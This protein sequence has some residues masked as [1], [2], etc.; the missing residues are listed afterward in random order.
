M[1]QY[2][3]IRKFVT[4]LVINIFLVFLTG[5]IR[6]QDTCF[7][8]SA[9][10]LS[11][12]I[13]G[14]ELNRPAFLAISNGTNQPA[15]IVITRYNGGSPLITNQTIQPG[16][17]YKLDF[18]TMSDMKTVENPRSLAGSVTT[19]GVHI[20]SDVGVSAYY[21]ANSYDSRDIFTLKG[22][23]ALGDSFYVPMQDAN[24]Y[25]QT[26]PYSGAC[27]QIDIVATEDNTQVTVVP[28]K[29]VWIAYPAPGSESPAGT[30]IVRTLNRGQ[31][32]K[33]M[34]S[35]YGMSTS[36][37]SYINKG[38]LAGTSITATHPVAVTV[39]EDLVAGDTSGDQIV[40]VNSV[41]KRYVIA[42]GY[43]TTAARERLYM[44]ATVNGTSIR[45]NGVTVASGMNA[46]DVR[47]D[48]IK[49][50]VV[51]VEANNPIYCYQRTGYN[52]QGAALLPSMY[53]ISQHQITFLQVSAQE[54][55]GFVVYKT[56]TH[57]DFTITYGGT[58][59][60]LSNSPVQTLTPIA[61]PGIAEWSV[62]RFNLPPLAGTLGNVNQVMTLSN[63]QSKFSLGYIGANVSP[64]TMTFYGYLSQFGK[65]SFADTI[66]MCED[67]VKLD[68]GYALSYD[69]T[70]PDGTHR[71]TSTI[72][73]ADTGVYSVTVNLDPFLQTTT[74][75]LIRRFQGSAIVSSSASEVGAGSYT[76]SVN[77]GI[78]PPTNIRYTWLIDGITVSNNPT[79]SAVWNDNE[80][81]EIS[82][83]LQDTVIGCSKTHVL[84][85][86]Q[87]P[88][89]IVLSD[90]YILPPATP[91]SINPPIFSS[92]GNRVNTYYPIVVGD[93]NGDGQSEIITFDKSLNGTTRNTGNIQIFSSN[94][95]LLK[96]LTLP[97]GHGATCDATGVIGIVRIPVQGA[98]ATWRSLIVVAG[99]NGST[100]NYLYAYAIDSAMDIASMPATPYWTSN[101]T[102]W[103]TRFVNLGFADFNHD[104]T[105]EI[106]VGRSI[107][108]AATGKLLV[109]ATGGTSAAAAPIHFS[110]NYSSPALHQMAAD[111]LGT[112]TP[113][114]I[115]GNEIYEV[116]IADT[117]GTN[118]SANSYT[119]A[120][121]A[122]SDNGGV[123][124]T[125]GHVC[126]ADFDN[127]GHTDILITNKNGNDVRF[128]LWNPTKRTVSPAIT[129]SGF[130]GTSQ[131][132]N[133]PMLGDIDGDG[134]VEIVTL[135]SPSSLIALKYDP[136][137]GNLSP[138]YPFKLFWN[139][140]VNDDTGSTGLTMF[141]FNQDGISELVY[142]DND[143]LRI[144]NGSGKSHITHN[145]T[146]NLSGNPVVYNLATFV[147]RSA[148]GTEYPVIADIDHD[149]KADIIITGAA[150]G[151]PLTDGEIRIFKGNNW[152]P[153]RSVWNQYSY[154]VVNV[155]EDLSVPRYQMNP[156]MFFPN[157]K[158]P[159]N[160]FLQQQ[161]KLDRNGNPLWLLP[162]ITPVPPL[163]S[164][165][166]IDD[167]VSVTVAIIN[168]GDAAINP[169]LHYSLYKESVSS[170]TF[171][172]NDSVMMQINAGETATFTFKI[173]TVSIQPA[174]RL[175]VRIND[176]GGLFTVQPE[177]KD[178]NNV[179]NF[180][181]PALSKLMTKNSKINATPYNGIRSNP[182]AVFHTDTILYS[183]TAFNGNTGAGVVK[184]SDVLPAYLKYASWSSPPI[185]ATPAGSSPARDSLGWE[186]SGIAPLTY[187]TVYFKA[188]PIEGVCAS[189]PL[190][191]NRAW[192]T[193]SDTITV[194]T[195]YTY[196]QGAG[197]CFI[198]FS[199]GYGGSI[200]HAAEQALDYRTTPR[201]G[202]VVAPNEGY[203]FAGWR[204]DEYVSLRGE[205][206]RARSGI[207]LYDTLTVYGN[208][209]L[210]AEFE[211]DMYP[212]TYHLNGG[213]NSEN[214]PRS[215]TIESPDFRLLPPAKLNDAF[216]GWTGSNGDV[217]QLSVTIPKGSTGERI[218]YA[219]YLRSGRS[220]DTLQVV[221][222]NDKVWTVGNDLHVRTTKPGSILRI[223][224]ID[225]VL[226][227]QQTLL[228]PGETKYRLPNGVYII[229]LNN[230]VGKKVMVLYG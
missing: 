75:R 147:C 27:D 229:T 192:V 74:T 206:I 127:D 143:S 130:G 216:T 132:K 204:H 73:A 19:F 117:T 188:T 215:Y 119:L 214:N 134:K 149:G 145:D 141:D 187:T 37:A 223:Y 2:S 47:M 160:N 126:I 29:T 36:L 220:V 4:V 167:S 103:N 42:K 40:P 67:S 109:T 199:A 5:Q 89:N 225:G 155:N 124:T 159:Y 181:N 221:A 154:N 50:D 3:K 46:G 218:Y 53:S 32:L 99:S 169:P 51:Y 28:K 226:I 98:V 60:L 179:I 63:P 163:S 92:T 13:A 171:I 209:T 228:Q 222:E 56:G 120:R 123:A 9:P 185:S 18:S 158:Q 6:A 165:A 146:L 22:Q 177:C 148:T 176:K 156:A 38:S 116:H 59:Y 189:Q 224:S 193:V 90:C 133:I 136:T 106:H 144:I 79:Y 65:L 201:S 150:T 196:H 21:M 48:T 81:R 175:F 128:Y 170:G 14:I 49:T 30:P 94:A 172:K 213:E 217:P 118:N 211:L 41:G 161:T 84:V 95:V 197:V 68:A 105:P 202:I 205:K 111:V 44:I 140:A 138:Y 208:M 180:I 168:Q 212:I 55:K 178:G 11:E 34:E 166:L 87:L 219:N 58:T 137:P 1:V 62:L 97:S 142:R 17:L 131:S 71:N 35:S 82:M 10:H 157:G 195:N 200:Y 210:Q 7:W 129:L 186:I 57:N 66:Y 80:D 152:A 107:F 52:E 8:F 203:R 69:W 76:Y 114:M 174:F 26:G 182:V 184:I 72:M 15:N 227:R 23:A 101:A 135:A 207:M 191:D 162:D 77:T 70:L 194:P 102:Y 96:T 39:T 112:G 16:N 93:L 91:W 115:L 12:Q 113:Q 153:A 61:V 164:V 121:S 54:Q 190:F 24:N 110:M 100:T 108:N 33:I 85:H 88:D 45:I 104:G 125:D 64:N 25:E 151:L 78:H 43:M 122:T 86:H 139:Y 83:I 20:S 230:G 198:T 31:T 173:D 183:I